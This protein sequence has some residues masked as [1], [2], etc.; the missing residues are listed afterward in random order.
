MV[1]A[2]TSVSLLCY[3]PFFSLNS[4]LSLEKENY[5]DICVF[6]LI[7]VHVHVHVHVNVNV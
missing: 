3:P 1:A 6:F 4:F 2:A 5:I 7:F